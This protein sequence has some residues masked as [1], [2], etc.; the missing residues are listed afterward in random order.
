MDSTNASATI[1]DDEAVAALLKQGAL[2]PCAECGKLHARTA[3]GFNVTVAG[4]PACSWHCVGELWEG[5]MP[6]E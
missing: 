3:R 1:S 6:D 2:V 5:G 4:Q